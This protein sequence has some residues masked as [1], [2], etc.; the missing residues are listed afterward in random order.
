MTGAALAA[1]IAASAAAA[2]PPAD[3]V[4]RAL[5]RI[6]SLVAQEHG[7]DARDIAA[8]DKRAEDEFKNVAPLGWHAAAPLGAAAQ[9]RSLAPKTRLF[10][11]VFLGKL[12]DAAAFAPLSS[13]LLD[14]EQDADVRLAAAQALTGLDV[15]PASARRTFCA[16]LA[17]EALPRALRDQTLVALE[18]LGCG[19]GA[20][21]ERTARA[22]G[23]R[24]EGLD[25]AALRRALAA[26][27]R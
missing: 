12:G 24:P 6:D 2:P 10:A 1:L 16:A 8:L 26:L 22:L 7:K 20:A 5:A 27:A 19:D 14:A 3:A 9:D 21:L 18:R 17:Q 25:R 4:A 23:A 11:V 13:V 15:P